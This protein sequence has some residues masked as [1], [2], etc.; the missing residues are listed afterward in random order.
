VS[1]QGGSTSLAGRVAIVTGAGRGI[2]AAIAHLL[3]ERGA[4]VG[5]NDVDS[6]TAHAM[7]ATVTEKGRSAEA[8][9]G[10]VS[11]AAEAGAIVRRMLEA[12]GRVDVLVNNAGIGGTGKHLHELTEEEWNRM[13][14]VNL[15]SVFLMCRAVVPMMSGKGWGRIVNMSSIFG[16][17]GAAGSTHYAATKAGI[18]GFSKSLARELAANRI[19][20]NVVAPGLI[21]TPMFRARGV[22][23][24]PPWLLWPRVGVPEDVAET[25]AFLCSDAA[26]FITG[27]VISPNGGGWM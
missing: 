6:A 13:M 3:A 11:V 1:D 7:A 25:V 17:S 19:T 9:P 12:H 20:V 8:L 2:G 14:Q 22:S 5:V 23:P 10:D 21:D 16:L 24:G 26:E 18:I 4:C 27:Q 15:G